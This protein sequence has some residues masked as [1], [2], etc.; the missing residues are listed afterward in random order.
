MTAQEG[1]PLSAT[2]AE[3]VVALRRLAMVFYATIFFS[4]GTLDGN[5]PGTLDEVA[6]MGE[7]YARMASGTLDLRTPESQAS[8]G[9][10]ML[11]RALTGD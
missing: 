8:F 3:L 11:R 6:R 7:L 9:A 2:Q 1:A 5:V 10:A 4:L